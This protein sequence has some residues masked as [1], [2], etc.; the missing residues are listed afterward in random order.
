MAAASRIIMIIIS[1]LQFLFPFFEYEGDLLPTEPSESITQE[2]TTEE[3]TTLPAGCK[4]IGGD[5]TCSVRAICIRCGEEYGE[6]APHDNTFIVSQVT[7]TEDGYT[8]YTCKTCGHSSKGDIVKAQGHSYKSRVI[9]PTC[10]EPGR[11]V[12]S[13][14][15]CGDYY[16]EDEVPAIGHDYVM[17]E[18]L[19]DCVNP[20]YFVYTCNNC[21]DVYKE[22]TDKEL[23]HNYVGVDT[24]PTCEGIG[25]TTYT[26]P[27]CGDSY[28]DNEVPA[29]GH[30]FTNY[31]PDGNASCSKDGTK[32]AKCDNGCGNEDTIADVGSIRPHIDEDKNKYCDIGGEE[33]H[34]SFTHLTYPEAAVKPIVDGWGLTIKNITDR[35]NSNNTDAYAENKGYT[36]ANGVFVSP[37]HRVKV[38]GVSVPAYGALTYSGTKSTGT[39]HSFSEIYVEKGEYSTFRIEIESIN[40]EFTIED[41]IVLPEAYGETVTVENGTAT[42]I[43]SGFGAHTFLFN[44][45]DQTYAYTIFVYEE[46]DDDAE[47]AKLKEQGYTVYEVSGYLPH[48]YTVFS[49]R[50]TAKS[51]IYLRKGA[52]VTANHLYD[53]DSD[54]DNSSKAETIDGEAASKHNGIGLNRCP[55]IGVHDTNDIKILGYGVIDLTDLDRAERRGIVI[56]YSNN[57]EVRGVRI[58]NAPE[59][60]FISYRCDNLTVK[61]VSIFGYRLNSD[62]FDICNS[63][64]VTIDGCFARSGDDLF[65]VK[66]L[67]GDDNAIAN[68]ITFTNC[69]AWAAKARA[70]GLFGES[71]RSVSD[72]TFKDCYVLMHDATWDYNRIP[73]IGIVAESVDSGNTKPISFTNIT[74]ENIE[75]SRNYAAA[76]NVLVFKQISN[77]FTIDNVTFRNVSYRSNNVLNRINKYGANSSISNV[78]FEN[79]TCNGTKVV[80]SNKTAYFSQESYWGGYITVK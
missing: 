58:I 19:P 71:N 1:I 3:Q 12:F 16:S 7:C 79:T 23:G 30:S 36:D 24:L 62:A 66:A 18:T 5:A 74:F 39:I 42:A 53:I 70:F 44:E 51:V 57:V 15:G 40:S 65:A 17:T 14:S 78:T 20:G 28:R 43:L 6:Y 60:S 34:M 27:G 64:N 47:I 8:I 73:A 9:E 72:V 63:T 76:A 38:D 37:Y 4:H 35:A 2:V 21:G 69:Y 32:T 22:K 56:D 80:D 41:A 61:N 11:T 59:W 68:N 13:C 29:T 75:I 77:N 25:Y 10:E 31:V 49:G 33:L 45:E 48:D 46:V 26:C 54:A 67:G 55:F 50:N 52:Y